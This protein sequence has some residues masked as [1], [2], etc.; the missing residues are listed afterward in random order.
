MDW[1]IE[2]VHNIHLVYRLFLRGRVDWNFGSWKIYIKHRVSSYAEEWIEIMSFIHLKN[3]AIVSS[4]A[5]EW[6]E[7]EYGYEQII[8]EQCLFL[9]GRVDW[10]RKSTNT[11]RFIA[12][13]L[14]TR[15]SGLKSIRIKTI[16]QFTQSLP[17]RKSGLKYYLSAPTA[18]T[19][20]GL[21]LRGRVDWNLIH[22]TC[23][24]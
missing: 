2:I 24:L 1:N 11:F 8:K 6:I 20:S 21:F 14:P 5:E 9:R 18:L 3:C 17:T 22:K 4:Y 12:S 16:R 23:N 19:G 13:S 15:K 10:N 7:I